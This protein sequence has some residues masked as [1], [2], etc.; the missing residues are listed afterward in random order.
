MSIHSSRMEAARAEHSTAW[1]IPLLLL[2]TAILV[3]AGCGNVSRGVL[4]D[5]TNAS[6]LVWPSPNSLTPM[7]K[8]GTF[9]EP[10]QLQLIHQGMNKQQISTL[11]GYPHFSEGVWAVREW[12]YV[13]NF[14]EEGS[15]HVDICQFKILFDEDKIAR[16]FYW[17]P[18]AC[19]SHMAA[20]I[21]PAMAKVAEQNVSPLMVKATEQ[22]FSIQ[23]ATP[24]EQQVVLSA[25]AMFNFDR[26]S[27]SDIT[28]DGRVQL[29]MLAQKLITEP[30][31]IVEIHI[32]GY[33]DRVGGDDYDLAL[34][35]RR[36]YSVTEYLVTKG[37]PQD[38]IHA[39]GR[40]KSDAIKECPSMPKAALIECLAPNR[41]VVLQ[42]I[43]RMK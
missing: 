26:T 35:K 28:D 19:S 13:F 30:N 1:C 41:R 31:D 4:K 37:V 17:Y 7:H 36:A 9:P 5:G 10:V 40:G 24:P 29:D 23:I 12:N 34:S 16:S 39:E 2:T 25:D 21:A 18:D 27:I 6:Q 42:V 14:R 11:I 20:P 38:L 3:L 32:R 15:D 33:S 43:T 8:G 22:P